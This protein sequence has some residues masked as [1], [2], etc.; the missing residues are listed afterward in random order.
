MSLSPQLHCREIGAEDLDRIVD[1][2]TTGYGIRGRDFW[3]RRIRRLSEYSA[4]SGFPK[5]GYLLDYN[6]APVGVIFTIFSPIIVNNVKTFRCYLANW[7]VEPKYRSY[8]VMLATYAVKNKHVTY[9]I[10]TPSQYTLPILQAL[11]YK[12]FCKGRFV[13]VPTLSFRSDNAHVKLV[14][15]N[16]SANDNIQ[17]PEVELLLGH[18]RYGC[19]SLTCLSA[20]GEYPFIFQPRLKTGVLPFARLVYCRDL[21]DFVRFAGPLG[22]FLIRRGFPLVVLDTNGPIPELIGKYSGS[23]PKYFKGPDQPRLEDSAYSARVIFDF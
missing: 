16:R 9:R 2:L 23:F 19:I 4:P 21:G 5:Y 20:E 10:G 14:A 3:A 15:P 1:L 12:L 11:G 13:S 17:S 6:G 7:Y 8:A 22:R 18:A